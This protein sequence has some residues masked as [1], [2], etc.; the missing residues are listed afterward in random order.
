MICHEIPKINNIEKN[1]LLKLDG[2][3]NFFPL[4]IYEDLTKS[5]AIDKEKK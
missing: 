1:E 2:L 3:F 4:K 5:N